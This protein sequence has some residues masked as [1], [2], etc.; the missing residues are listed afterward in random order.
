LEISVSRRPELP[1]SMPRQGAKL[2]RRLSLPQCW[3]A[4]V[5]RQEA[6]YLHLSVAAMLPSPE[7]PRWQT[8]PQLSPLVQKQL[9][10][11]A[12]RTTCPPITSPMMKLASK[13]WTHLKTLSLNA[14]HWR[15]LPHAIAG[16]LELLTTRLLQSKSAILHQTALL[17]L[18]QE[19]SARLHS[20]RAGSMK[21]TSLWS[22]LP[23]TRIL[24][25]L[26]AS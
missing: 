20:E 5:R 17:W 19:R 23:V 7:Q 3:L 18:L 9:T 26:R 12:T 15:E 6:I 11:C 1:R 16:W 21:T 4:L 24:M 25:H 8:S 14:L 22:F 10:T 2:I 13:R